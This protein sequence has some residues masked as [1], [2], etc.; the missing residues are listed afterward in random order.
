MEKLGFV[1]KLEVVKEDVLFS[2]DDP[3]Q[4]SYLDFKFDFTYRFEVVEF[5]PWWHVDL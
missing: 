4:L 3:L 1:K 5:L 2:W